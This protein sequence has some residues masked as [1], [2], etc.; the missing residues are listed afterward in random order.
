MKTFKGQSIQTCE[1][2]RHLYVSRAIFSM[3][4]H[5]YLFVSCCYFVL[6][7]ERETREEI[8]HTQTRPKKELL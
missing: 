3:Q 2:W 5:A 4:V 6:I 7:G 8:M 1:L